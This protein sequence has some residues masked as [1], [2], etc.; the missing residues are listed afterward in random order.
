MFVITDLLGQ[1]RELEHIQCLVKAGRVLVD[2][3]HHGDAA[4]TT[5]EELQEVCELGLPEG[6]VVLKPAESTCT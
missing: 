3:D 5:E 4:G 6:N 1:G 2:V